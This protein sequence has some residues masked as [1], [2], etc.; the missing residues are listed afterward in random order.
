M[1]WIL[2][3]SYRILSLLTYLTYMSPKTCCMQTWLNLGL[4][5]LFLS[6]WLPWKP[7]CKEFIA[8]FLAFGGTFLVWF[9]F[10]HKIFLPTSRNDDSEMTFYLKDFHR[11]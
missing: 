7:D 1:Y 2:L 5:F 8:V 4:P 10:Q 9:Q 3:K 6:D 11:P